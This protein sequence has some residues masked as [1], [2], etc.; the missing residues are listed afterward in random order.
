MVKMVMLCGLPGS[1]KSTYCD[2]YKYNKDYIILSS[3][4]VRKELGDIN[5]QSKNEEVFNILHRRIKDNLR[6]G[7]SVCYDATNLSRKR[8]VAFLRELKNISCEKICVLVATPY[9]MCVVQNFKRDRRVPVEVIWN[10]Y[11]SFNVPCEQ[12]GWDE[13]IVHYPNEE[14]KE[15]YGNIA[16]HVNELCDFDQENH[17]HALTLGVHMK[18]A[19]NYLFDVL[20]KESDVVHAAFTHDIGKV[21]TKEFKNGKGEP[22]EEAHYYNH[23]C[24]GA[25]KSLFFEYPSRVNKMYVSLLIELHMKP[26]LEWKQSGKSK[27]KDKVLFGDKVFDD[28]MMLH[29]ADVW[30]H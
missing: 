13:I 6:D 1:G 30:A 23:H 12:E 10:M 21:D 26:Y 7:K 5:D 4:E 14:W 3:D 9:E 20:R 11:K 29:Q 2:K 28:V 22:T 15:Y 19:G 18:K 25:Y 24:L 27:E 17:H 16:D 8:R